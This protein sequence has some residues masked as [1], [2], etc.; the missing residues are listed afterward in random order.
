MKAISN[1]A[2]SVALVSFANGVLNLLPVDDGCVIS[3]WAQ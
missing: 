3:K 1:N 2:F